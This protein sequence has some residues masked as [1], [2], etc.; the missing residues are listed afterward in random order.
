MAVGPRVFTLPVNG[1]GVVPEGSDASLYAAGGVEGI[2]GYAVD[3]G[4]NLILTVFN[5]AASVRLRL[6]VRQVVLRSDQLGPDPYQVINTTHT[7]TSDGAANTFIVPL[8]KGYVVSAYIAVDSGSPAATDCYVEL[9]IAPNTGRTRKDQITVLLSG[10]VT[11]QY[12]LSSAYNANNAITGQGSLVVWS[13][14]GSATASITQA[15]PTA[16]RWNF[17]VGK[18]TITTSAVA[19]NRRPRFRVTRSAVVIADFPVHVDM[20][21][22]LTYTFLWGDYDTDTAADTI[23]AGTDVIV[24]TRTAGMKTL[25]ADT[26]SI[27]F[28]GNQAGDTCTGGTFQLESWVST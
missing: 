10:Y 7:P 16:T 23:T 8:Y 28:T 1:P 3:R 25:P 24:R 5:T 18:V 20:A 9:G 2:S 11:S 19:G 13:F 21:A 6:N 26:L 15:V 27:V 22:S 14:S 17:L 4:E 12:A